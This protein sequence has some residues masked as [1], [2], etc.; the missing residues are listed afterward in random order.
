M[1]RW[2]NAH[3]SCQAEP[4][5]AA[6]PKES[7]GPLEHRAGLEPHRLARLDLDRLTGAGIERLAGLGLM[8]REG[9]EGGQGEAAFRLQF[10]R[11]RVEQIGGRLLRRD[12]GAVERVLKNSCDKSLAH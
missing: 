3:E 9:A 12:P 6:R 11:D 2:P 10:G 7:D 5:D 4:R 8:D 1:R